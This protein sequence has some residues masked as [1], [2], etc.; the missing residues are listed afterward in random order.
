MKI[1]EMG[2]N[3]VVIV[4]MIVTIV[5][6]VAGTVA[7]VVLLKPREGPA[8]SGPATTTPTTT[9]P[10]APPQVTALCFETA[11]FIDRENTGVEAFSIII[12]AEWHLQGG[13]IWRAERPL[14]PASLAFSVTSPGGLEGLEVFPDEAYFWV[15][16]EGL[17]IPYDYGP[18]L[19]A[20][21]ALE[22]QGYGAL[23]PM[24]A[25]EYI[26]GI[27]IPKYR[28]GAGALQIVGITS[29]HESDTVHQLEDLLA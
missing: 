8:P 6:V 28:A 24:S 2:I 12:P 13:I 19:R 7:A 23:Q 5:V 20:E 10:G 9:A 11:E 25:A 22:Y 3:T 4:V 15:E 27:L 29:L 1:G 26:A 14:L 21:Y 16:G 17:W 18:E